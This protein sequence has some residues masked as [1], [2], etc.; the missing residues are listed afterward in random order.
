MVAV[1]HR[2]VITTWSCRN[3]LSDFKKCICSQDTHIVPISGYTIQWQYNN[4]RYCCVFAHEWRR[5]S[6]RLITWHT[7]VV[8]LVRSKRFSTEGTFTN[9]VIPSFDDTFFN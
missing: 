5:H 9:N 1:S 6:K 7:S 2:F 4:N 8:Y 3:V